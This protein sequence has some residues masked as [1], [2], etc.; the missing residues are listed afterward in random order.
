MLVY[1]G[2]SPKIWNGLAA[3]VKSCIFYSILDFLQKLTRNEVLYAILRN[4]LDFK[5]TVLSTSFKVLKTKLNNQITVA[6]DPIV[7]N[8]P[9]VFIQWLPFGVCLVE[10][11]SFDRWI[12]NLFM[13]IEKLILGIIV[14]GFIS[15][16][17]SGK[18]LPYIF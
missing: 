15:D 3:K 1:K 18:N 13:S 4:S 6:L 11:Y 14:K 7:P 5:S 17:I 2:K 16:P 12:L 9:N 10:N 8:Y